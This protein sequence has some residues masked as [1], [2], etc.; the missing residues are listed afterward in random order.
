MCTPLGLAVE[1]ATEESQPKKLPRRERLQTH[2]RPFG[3]DLLGEELRSGKAGAPDSDPGY[4]ILCCP[5]GKTPKRV[6]NPPP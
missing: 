5:S 2:M 4:E 1:I 6:V 3:A